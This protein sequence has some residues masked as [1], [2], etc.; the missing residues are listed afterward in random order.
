MLITRS[1]GN[2]YLANSFSES[3]SLKLSKKAQLE[4]FEN[5][6]SNHNLEYV[7][8]HKT[9]T[10]LLVS[11]AKTKCLSLG[12]AALSHFSDVDS[13]V[14]VDR[15]SEKNEFI[16]VCSHK[17]QIIADLFVTDDD[18]PAY[19][20]ANALATEPR[21]TI[22]TSSEIPEFI[23]AFYRERGEEA[24]LN[25]L[26]VFRDSSILDELPVLPG[27]SYRPYEL[28]HSS[29]QNTSRLPVR[30]IL[31]FLMIIGALGLLLTGE[32]AEDEAMANVPMIDP[33]DGYKALLGGSD[34]STVTKNIYKV[35]TR[36]E[37]SYLW[38]FSSC[39]YT[40]GMPM[41]CELHPSISSRTSDLNRIEK[42]V[43][44]G[45]KVDLV[46]SRAV[47]V[48]PIEQFNPNRK[49]LI[50]N[51]KALV[52]L[53]FDKVLSSGIAT[54]LSVSTAAHDSNWITQI[55]KFG[56]NR[57]GLYNLALIAEATNGLT[58]NVEAVTITRE[59]NFYSI[60]YSINSFGGKQ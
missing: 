2:G 20:L 56:S 3:I 55:I 12:G 27:L 35:L 17:G 59:D 31:L 11:F 28:V 43:G 52:Q 29:F 15:I 51:H 60:D 58:L 4:S 21:K 8:I 38:K 57:T 50:T 32:N 25:E 26:V 34:A 13:F 24:V 10:D 16:F 1:D 41:I 7:Y 45:A 46:D 14:W 23:T 37:N 49:D 47:V 18:V 36:L 53:V 48:I 6:H 54:Q 30:K 33:Y 9:D 22:Y 40:A 5:L 19:V 39:N 44:G 42:L